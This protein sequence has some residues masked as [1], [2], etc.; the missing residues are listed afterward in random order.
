VGLGERNGIRV[1]LAP[2][3]LARLLR[4]IYAAALGGAADDWSQLDAEMAEERHSAVPLHATR[5]YANPATAD[6]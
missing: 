5:I 6:E 4:A 1:G 2:R 3:Q